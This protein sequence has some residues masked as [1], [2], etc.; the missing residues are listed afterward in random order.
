M[1]S[2]LRIAVLVFI[3]F[4]AAC[5]QDVLPV[6][7]DTQP[8]VPLEDLVN[9]YVAMNL[10]IPP[11][12]AE[13][14][15][16]EPG[17]IALVNGGEVHDRF[18]MFVLAKREGTTV[19]LIGT[20]NVAVGDG[21]FKPVVNP[22]DA[23]ETE[24]SPL[25][26]GPFGNGSDDTNADDELAVAIQCE[27]TG[28][29][30]V[31]V[32]LYNRQSR[33]DIG[34]LQV[35]ALRSWKNEI[36]APGSDRKAILEKIAAL[37]TQQEDGAVSGNLADLV[38]EP[39]AIPKDPLEAAV[40]SMADA[41]MVTSP[42]SNRLSPAPVDKDGVWQ[43]VPSEPDPNYL[44]VRHDV[45]KAIPFLL[46]HLDDRTLSRSYTAAY[47]QIKPAC[48]DLGNLC[49]VVLAELTG[50]EGL[51]GTKREDLKKAALDIQT[52]AAKGEE[53]FLMSHV[54]AADPK[55]GGNQILLDTLA[56]KYPKDLVALFERSAARGRTDDLSRLEQAIIASSLPEEDRLGVFLEATNNRDM[57]VA[58]YGIQGLHAMHRPEEAARLAELIG[59][60]PVKPNAPYWNCVESA[61]MYYA[62][63]S[64]DERVWAAYNKWADR[65]EMGLRMEMIHRADYTAMPAATL[66]R[67][68]AFCRKFL[69]D[70]SVRRIS[71]DPAM[72]GGP[73][74]GFGYDTLRV[75]DLAAMELAYFLDIP[76]DH[77]PKSISSTLT[78]S[79][80]DP[81]EKSD[82]APSEAEWNALRGRVRQALE[83]YD[84]QSASGR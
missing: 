45:I 2:G 70:N 40:V 59:K 8:R 64:T 37:Q 60:L 21:T 69:T 18:L 33:A 31:A 7:D 38:P 51:F 80:A 30:D 26:A 11:K 17:D 14:V 56:A 13:L 22:A 42:W 82:P 54:L 65:A 32:M 15:V 78:V 39:S 53:A 66:R 72:F 1:R 76:G 83:T 3:F 29:H 19:A 79:P 68:I 57:N 43:S 75:G 34:L 23:N 55:K 35:L 49:Q 20:A 71:D 9:A 52:E 73:C 24:P 25:Y 74:A 61:F 67:R 10:P 6:A 63:M 44:Q 58:I 28:H 77:S 4:A 84:R 27:L 12:T 50:G 41:S 48:L 46:A 62:G 36:L 47:A 16:Y 5:S 81:N